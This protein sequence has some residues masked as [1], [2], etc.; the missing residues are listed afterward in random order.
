[1]KLDE[2]TFHKKRSRMNNLMLFWTVCVIIY[3]LVDFYFNYISYFF[4]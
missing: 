3:S 4:L 1:M 2:E